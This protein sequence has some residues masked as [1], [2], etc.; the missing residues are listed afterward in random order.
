MQHVPHEII[1]I[2]YCSQL[3][4]K[5]KPKEEYSA[6]EFVIIALVSF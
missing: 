1:I 6:Y 2:A 4:G 3:N 5:Y